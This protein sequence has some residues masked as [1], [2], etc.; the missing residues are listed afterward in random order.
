MTTQIMRYQYS[1]AAL[2]MALW[3]AATPAF[4]ESNADETSLFQARIKD[5][6]RNLADRPAFKNLSAA[7]REKLMD[8]IVGNMLFVI[9]HELGHAAITEMRLPV[10]GRPE[11]PPTRLRPSG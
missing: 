11:A 2:S 1:L 10:L 5:A 9:L 6:A 3:F 4:A 7:D 8:F